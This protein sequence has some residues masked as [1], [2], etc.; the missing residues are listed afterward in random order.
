MDELLQ[1]MHDTMNPVAGIKG[2]A[3]LLKS[4]NVSPEDTKKLLDAI[5]DRADRLNAV[6]DAYYIRRREEENSK[7]L[8]S[9]EDL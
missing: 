3:E 6:L 5:S 1:L 9:Q 2:A 7:K 4:G 8:D